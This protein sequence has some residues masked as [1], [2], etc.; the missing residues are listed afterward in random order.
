[1][2][3]ISKWLIMV[4]SGSKWWLRWYSGIEESE[5]VWRTDISD[6]VRSWSIIG[7]LKKMIEEGLFFGGGGR[8]GVVTHFLFVCV[9]KEPHAFEIDS[10]FSSFF[11]LLPPLAPS[12]EAAATDADQ[13]QSDT[14]E[15]Q[16]D[17]PHRNWNYQPIAPLY[18]VF[19]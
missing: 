2:L 1:M 8:E 3:R 9:S 18:T 4:V 19:L 5:K 14:D 16:D 12:S 17:S 10:A 13:Q 15:Y 7:G 6:D 11:V